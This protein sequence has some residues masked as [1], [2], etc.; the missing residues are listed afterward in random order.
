MF[1]TLPGAYLSLI[2][3]IVICGMIYFKGIALITDGNW[4]L[5]IQNSNA[6][7][8]DMSEYVNI[9]QKHPNLTIGIELGK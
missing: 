9:G 5:L 3:L 8:A 6:N 7:D 2:L 4:E 1:Q